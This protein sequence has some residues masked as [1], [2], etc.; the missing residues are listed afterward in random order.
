MSETSEVE[1]EAGQ[2]YLS[3]KGGLLIEIVYVGEEEATTKWHSYI[4][5]Y[6]TNTYAEKKG[7]R[8]IAYW[9]NLIQGKLISA[10]QAKALI[11]MWRTH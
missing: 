6:Y 7:A 2:Y 8:T 10:E 4:E 1:Y 9:V 5:E 11:E 3:A